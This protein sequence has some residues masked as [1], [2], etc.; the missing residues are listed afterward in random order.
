MKIAFIPSTFLPDVGGAEIQAHNLA[1]KL[2]EEGNQVDV[3]LL[4]KVTIKNANYK[5]IT[6][7]KYFISLVFLLK[8]YFSINLSFFCKALGIFY[9]LLHKCRQPDVRLYRYYTF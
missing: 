2:V 6:L 9:F 3:Y 8:Y 1:N 4:N 7:N 5:I